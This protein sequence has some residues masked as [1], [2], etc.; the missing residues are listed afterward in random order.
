MAA[1]RLR[2]HRFKSSCAYMERN[3]TYIDVFPFQFLK[4]P[5]SKMQS[6]SGCSHGSFLLAEYRLV[7]FLVIWRNFSFD[8]GRQWYVAGRVNHFNER[9]RLVPGKFN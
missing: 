1:N 2:L 9:E 4:R 3:K 5:G 7:S 8:I 6:S